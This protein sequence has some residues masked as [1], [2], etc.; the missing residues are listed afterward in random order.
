MLRLGR[1]QFRASSLRQAQR[2]LHASSS[3]HQTKGT[4][5]PGSKTS[6][7]KTPDKINYNNAQFNDVP[8][9]EQLNYR[10]VTANDLE[11]R[12]EPPTKV[13]MLVRDFIEDS[14]YN[15]NY[16][17]F[18]KQ[19]TNFTSSE[20]MDFGKLRDNAEFE[21]AVAQRYASYG[22][23]EEGP[24]SQIWHTPT[25]LFKVSSC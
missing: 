21:S 14:L 13:R 9:P 20:T 24:G 12:T 5:S 3:L 19:V 10:K 17:Y 16:G 18:P 23:V 4:S 1:T 15:P 2:C 8:E 22:L 6:K 25:E 7:R 11:S